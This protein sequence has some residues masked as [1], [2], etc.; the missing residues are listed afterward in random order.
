MFIEDQERFTS[1]NK[2]W[3]CN[4]L[5]VAG[6]KKK[7]RDR[8]YRTGKYRGF[9]HSNFNINLKLTKKV[10][11]IFHNLKDYDG[12]EIDKFNAERSVMSNG[13]EKYMAFTINKKFGYY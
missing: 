7:V 3:I 11:V 1:V 9:D 8:D 10:P 5:S 13:L 4:K 6:D 2:C 12:Q